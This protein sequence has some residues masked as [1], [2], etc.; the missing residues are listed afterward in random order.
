VELYDRDG[1]A[2]DRYDPGGDVAHQGLRYEAAEAARCLN[3]G[4]TESSL[5]P[6]A[7][8]VRTM[9]AMDEIRH[10]LGVHFRDE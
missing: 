8:T 6:L 7:T 3:A 4:A 2:I 1:V 10:Q 9:A 5:H